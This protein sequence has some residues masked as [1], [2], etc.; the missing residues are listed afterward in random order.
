MGVLSP[1]METLE[2]WGSEGNLQ[3]IQGRGGLSIHADMVGS[4]AV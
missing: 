3:S 2:I 1:R 4:M